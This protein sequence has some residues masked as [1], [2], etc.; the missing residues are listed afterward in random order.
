[1]TV[2]SPGAT[3]GILGGGQLGRML[4]LAAAELGF[5]VH[6]F[7]PEDD[8]PAAR[9]AARC[10]R[11][12]YDDTAALAAF[13]RAVD[14]VTFE[15]ENVPAATVEALVAAG[16]V[17]RPGARALAVAQD[18]LLEKAFLTEAGAPTVAHRRIDGPDDIPAALGALG[19]PALLKTRRL[20]YD[21]KGQAW[22]RS[23]ADAATAWAS[24]GAAPAIL[25]AAARFE[26]EISV[27]A[28]RGAD[29]AIAVYDVCENRH[30]DGILAETRVPA[31]APSATTAAAVAA[32][33][34]VLAALDYVGV[35]AIEFFVMPDGAV[36]ANEMAPRVHNSGHW[37]QDACIA[38]QFEN[39]IRAVAGWPLGDVTRFADVRM[40]NLI[41]D[42]AADWRA[43]AATP[44]AAVHLY[45]KR[46]ARP[47]RKMGH[48]TLLSN[49]RSSNGG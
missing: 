4:A 11:A 9:V 35:L 18:R 17:V 22:V 16:A 1:M 14:V 3:I 34:A 36:L 44:G 49:L 31:Q 47:G 40:L 24:I 33:R 45:G 27:I 30:A 7:T 26:R 42:A 39:Q 2:L 12:A 23:P 13:A 41:G 5:D 38:C 15:F 8:S 29:G 37:T 46:E 32:T 48:V 43:H 6:V 20:G 19:A 28:A 10:T 21:G 25:E